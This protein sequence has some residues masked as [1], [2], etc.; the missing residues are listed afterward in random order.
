MANTNECACL[1][2]LPCLEWVT[3]FR[4]FEI[5]FCSFDENGTRPLKI[6]ILQFKI[7]KINHCCVKSDV[8]LS[9]WT[10]VVVVVVVWCLVVFDTIHQ[11]N[12]QR[13][14]FYNSCT[15]TTQNHNSQQNPQFKSIQ[16]DAY[17][18]EFYFTQSFV[19]PILTHFYK[20][21]YNSFLFIIPSQ[22]Y[23]CNTIL[24]LLYIGTSEIFK[25][26]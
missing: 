26:W 7:G 3:L 16:F 25:N 24:T 19:L 2:A 13:F 6:K 9:Y 8:I 5:L 21:I 1:P 23:D 12:P 10:V 11:I 17:C 20:T 14:L 18:M 4:T 22:I 15:T